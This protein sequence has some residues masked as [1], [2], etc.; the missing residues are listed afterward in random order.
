T[1]VLNDGNQVG[2]IQPSVLVHRDGH[3]QAVGRTRNGHVFSTTSSDAG[4]TW[5]PLALLDLP[6]PS[7][8]IDAV[9][10]RDGRFLIVYNHTAT[11]RSPLNVAVSTDGQRWQ[12][13]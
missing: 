5:G 8:G 13:A 6:N 2:A 1:P 4:R 3:L 9:T 12:A 11:G 7:A 10:L